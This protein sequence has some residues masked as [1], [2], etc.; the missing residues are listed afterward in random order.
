MIKH[1]F[2]LV[3]IITS[4]NVSA[5]LTV[6]NSSYIYVDGNGFT[7]SQ[8]IAP[9]FVTDAVNLIGAD[10]NIY[11]RNEAQLIQGN[12]TGNTGTGKLSIY[13]TGT[14]NTYTYNFWSSP[15][16]NTDANN[17]VNRAFRANNNLYDLVSAPITSNLA[18]Y[19]TGYNGSSTPSLV[20][21]SFW[22]YTYDPGILYSDWDAIFETG[23]VNAGYGFTMKGNPSGAQ[24][25]DFRGKPHNGTL[26]A[27]I[28]NG[29]E[30]LVGNPYPS[31]LD[32]YYFI[33]DPLNTGI[34]DEFDPVDNPY[35]TGVLKYWEQQAGATSHALSNYVGGYAHYTIATDNDNG[36]PADLSDDS[37]F[38]S[39]VPAAFTMYLLDGSP[40]SG[41]PINGVKT[42]RRYI[43]VGQG[44][45][46]EGNT[47]GTV[48]F[49]NSQRT[50]Y[51]QS[52][53]ESYFFRTSNNA[54][55]SNA[56]IE[57]TT[58]EIQY[59]ENG[60]SIVPN[61]SKR[62]RINVGF[63]NNGNESYTRQLLMNFHHSATDGFDYGLEAKTEIE[64]ASDA[65]WVLNNDAYIIQAFD[66]DIE[67]K[68]PLVV[69]IGNEQ[70]SRFS[71]LDVQNFEINQPIYIH[72][73]ENDTYTNL[74]EQAYE[75]ILPTGDYTNRFEITF[76]TREA[77]HI[78]NITDEDF[79][80]FQNTKNAELTVLNPNELSIK[81]VTLIDVTG[82]VVINSKDLGIQNE[83]RF[84]T[85]SLSEGVY[86]ATVTVD[87]N[88]VISKKVVI[89]N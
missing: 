67:L 66:Y 81:S 24:L 38:E 88:Q 18:T 31:A 20:I 61:G 17:A 43:P 37:V 85:K 76:Q 51:K 16:G 23:T 73:I 89:K 53:T 26:T 1:I 35:F 13:Q 36:T 10:S 60:Q 46:I 65:H 79:E 62:F 47:N 87:N 69:K 50:F 63:D 27:A 14:A 86:I 75:L 8:N 7:S 64:L 49:R 39:F 9:I 15:V 55:N 78:E 5:Q 84:S 77:L 56:A 6:T 21:S 3:F 30:T 71:I 59:N 80:V 29:Q 68:I 44:F 25:Y 34:A 45:M 70:L 52:G 19:T 2:F 4:L 48:T 58:N 74:Q 72:D 83:Y 42:A 57:R 40:A 22:F 54:S 28:L 12:N 41:P 82:K 32:A 11:L 33:N